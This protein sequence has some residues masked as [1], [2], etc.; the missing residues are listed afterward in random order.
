MFFL[1]FFEKK[2]KTS[3]FFPFSM[4]FIRKKIFRKK[5]LLLIIFS[6]VKK[7]NDFLNFKR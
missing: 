7:K 6:K 1:G 4:G 3:H 5:N 2:M